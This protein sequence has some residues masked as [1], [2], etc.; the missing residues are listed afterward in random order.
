MQTMI[1]AEF[2]GTPVS[3]LDHLGR[4]WLTARDVGRCLG[5]AEAE[6]GNSINRL[7]SRHAD[8]FGL[9]DTCSVKLTDQVQAREVRIF[10]QTGCILLAMFAATPR[11]KE[12]R[13]WAKRALAAELPAQVA[14]K[15]GEAHT[16]RVSR[17][18]ERQA[19]ELFVAGLEMGSIARH[20]GVS[21]TVVS[22]LLSGQYR[23]ALNAGADETTPELLA[24]V[25]AEHLRRERGR[26]TERYI[27]SAANLRL[28]ARLEEVG[29]RMLSAIDAACP[30][31]EG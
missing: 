3:I 17:A 15:F 4:R 23:F 6:A 2:L 8:E 27:A 9:E 31:L 13:A 18:I 10:S 29:Q 16:V 20:L 19:M 1:R 12:F 26:I 30:A 11:A 24:A 7:Y 14:A 22:R 28:Q 5:Y 25:A 21:K